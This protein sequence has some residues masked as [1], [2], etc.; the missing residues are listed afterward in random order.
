METTANSPSGIRV[1]LIESISRKGAW[2]VWV[3]QPGIGQ[4]YL[5]IGFAWKTKTGAR[6]AAEKAF[7]GVKIEGA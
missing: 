5:R 7:P 4:G 1:K 2:H 3:S 6:K